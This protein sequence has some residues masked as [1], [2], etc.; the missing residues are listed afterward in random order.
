MRAFVAFVAFMQQCIDV[1]IRVAT[2]RASSTD[3]SCV[4]GFDAKSETDSCEPLLAPLFLVVLCH[5]RDTRVCRKRQMFEVYVFEASGNPE[6][7]FSA[8]WGRCGY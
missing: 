1:A 8:A 6:A 4:S 3:S 5:K 2:Y 7:F